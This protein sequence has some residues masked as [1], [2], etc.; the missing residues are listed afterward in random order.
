V[1]QHPSAPSCRWTSGPSPQRDSFRSARQ[2][3]ISTGAAPSKTRC[4]RTRSD[5]ACELRRIVAQVHAI[6]AA[7]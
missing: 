3:V 7:I 2:R 6:R 5:S 1:R 4:A